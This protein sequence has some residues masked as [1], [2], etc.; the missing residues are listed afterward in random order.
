MKTRRIISG[1]AVAATSA[2]WSAACSGTLPQACPDPAPLVQL[3][4]A[5]HVRYPQMQVADV[6]KL[7]QQAVV[8]SEHAIGDSAAVMHWMQREWETMGDGPV[9]PLVDTLGVRGSFARIH[10]RAFAGH[11]G[12]A[13]LLAMAFITTGRDYRG[14]ST[15]LSCAASAVEV[16]ARE[17]D[18]SWNADSMAAF[19]VS[20]AGRGYPAVGHSDAYRDA[21]KPAY[22]VV[23]L[24]LVDQVTSTESF[25]A[26]VEQVLSRTEKQME[27]RSVP[28]TPELKKN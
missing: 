5:H 28:R 6:F 3:V 26:H 10:L 15:A 17:R 9:E 24:P 1:F 11:G 23:A 14:D 13:S 22:R 16:A 19:R 21:Y 27:P 7:V 25:E 18:L 4:Q 12:D 2:L 20:W 8:G